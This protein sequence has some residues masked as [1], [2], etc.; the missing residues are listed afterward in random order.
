[1]ANLKKT[2]TTQEEKGC[3]PRVKDKHDNGHVQRQ[4]DKGRERERAIHTHTPLTHTHTQQNNSITTTAANNSNTAVAGQDRTGPNA[5]F[6][7]VVFHAASS[8]RSAAPVVA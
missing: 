4:R 7:S 5:G 3:K 8:G 1:M 2:K 6:L